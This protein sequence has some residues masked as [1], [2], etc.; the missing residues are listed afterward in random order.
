VL[1]PGP[2]A[3]LRRAKRAQRRRRAK[4]IYQQVDARDG[5]ICRCCGVFC[6][7]WR[8]Q[9]HIVPRSLGGRETTANL[10]T[11]C[12]FPV[13]NPGCHELVTAKRLRVIGLD[14][15]ETLTF[16]RMALTDEQSSCAE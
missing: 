13:R 2:T 16:E 4:S 12:A 9:H 3:R 8:Q 6:G 5:Q 11:L 15:N 14:A 7:H 1:K 10:V